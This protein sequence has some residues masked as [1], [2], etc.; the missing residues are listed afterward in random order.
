MAALLLY[1]VL[2]IAFGERIPVTDGLGTYDGRRYGEIAM[3][4]HREVFED[5]LDLFR[6]QRIIPSAI[7]HFGLRAIGAA[8]DPP[9]VVRAF[10]VLNL[11]CAL[12]LALTFHALAVTARLSGSAAG[13]GYA[14]LFLNFANLKQPFFYPVLTDSPA[15]LLGA[16]CLLFHLRRQ[17]RALFATLMVAAFSWPALFMSGSILF[18]VDDV[19]VDPAPA[20]PRPRT[21]LALATAGFL[22]L[23]A[24]TLGPA[25]GAPLEILSLG[26]LAAY[27]G[28]VAWTLSGRARLFTVAAW[29]EA[30]SVPRL[31]LVVAIFLALRFGLEAASTHPGMTLGRHIRHLFLYNSGRPGLFLLAHAVYFGVVAILLVVAW[32]RVSRSVHG[33]GL[34]LWAFTAFQA[35]HF[36]NTESRQLA[37]VLPLLVLLVVKAL[38]EGEEGAWPHPGVVVLAGLVLSKFWL[39]INIGEWGDPYQIPAQLYF[40]NHGPSMTLVTGGVQAAVVAMV[41]LGL[42]ASKGRKPQARPD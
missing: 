15:M 6:L 40:M 26:G 41:I 12:A 3:E 24:I 7:V 21:A 38:D 9:N 2:Q 42:A 13:L 18:F 11:A 37:D 33:F 30:V 23:L 34:G 1:G 22:A 19:V 36:I 17:R 4:F 10:L 5:G 14:L 39:P 31:A 28:V 32:T 29:R 27:G 20:R 25:P 16:L 8:L 35:G